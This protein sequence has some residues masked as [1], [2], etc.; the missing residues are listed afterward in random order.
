MGVGALLAAAAA[1]VVVVVV[2][3][4]AVVVVD[5]DDVRDGGV[6]VDAGPAGGVHA[7]DVRHLL[8]VLRARRKK[9][10]E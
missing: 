10:G 6:V 4:A 3:A 1:A 9:G 8:L 5:D 2:A 7:G